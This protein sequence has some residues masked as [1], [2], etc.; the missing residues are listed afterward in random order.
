MQE[1]CN[2]A[3]ASVVARILIYGPVKF[4]DLI[5]PGFF[6]RI[7]SIVPIQKSNEPTTLRR[8]NNINLMADVV[9]NM[10]QNKQRLKFSAWNQ[11]LQTTC[12]IY[13]KKTEAYIIIIHYC[14]IH[15]RPY[16]PEILWG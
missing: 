10:T 11:S 8:I 3:Q 13:R 4:S 15:F 2:S 16:A 14:L 9:S 5:I 12:S 6:V 7:R 1:T